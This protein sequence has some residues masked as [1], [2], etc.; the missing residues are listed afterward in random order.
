M[1]LVYTAIPPIVD[2]PPDECHS[3]ALGLVL[4]AASAMTLVASK[5]H[6]PRLS[7]PPLS[8]A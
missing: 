7:P 1:G 3:L 6:L 2:L 4:A 5:L 8:S